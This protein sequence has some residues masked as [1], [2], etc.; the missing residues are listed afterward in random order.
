M[1]ASLEKEYKQKLNI[2][3]TSKLLFIIGGGQGARELNDAVI[4]VLPH[5]LSEFKDLRVIHVVGS[6]NED[7]A[8]KMYHE[9]LEADQLNRVMIHGFTDTV[10]LFSGAADLIITRA[11][12]TNLAEFALQGKACIVVPAS[13]LV[14]GHQVKNAEI[15]ANKSAAIFIN[16]AEIEKDSN[17]LAKEVSQLLQDS[18]LRQQLSKNIQQFAYPDAGPHISEIVIKVAEGK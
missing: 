18:Q 4:E 3:A 11:G 10:Y 1:T 2:P 13:F 15:L 8:M 16:D 6:K 7:D 12:A 17:K 5:L 14:G 9:T